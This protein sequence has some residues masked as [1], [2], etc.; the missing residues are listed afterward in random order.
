MIK[1]FLR[2]IENRLLNLPFMAWILLG[3][4]VTFFL[5]FIRPV[6]LDP[7]L[8][9]Q[10][11]PYI[12]AL[13]PI[14][15]DYRAI[16]S[17]SY[18]WFHSGIVPPTLYPPLTLI[19]F[20][21]FSFIS[22]ETGY[23]ILVGIIL[24]CYLFTTLILPRWLNPHKDTS[25]FA[26]LLFVSGLVSY[27]FQFELERGQWNLI[28]FAFSLA[29]IYIFHKQTKYRWLAYF[30]FSLSVQLKLFPA[31]FIFSLIDNFSD[32]KNSLK[33]IIGLGVIN[34]IAL[35]LFGINPVLDTIKSFNEFSYNRVFIFNL[36]LSSFTSF[37][38][39]KRI[40][41]QKRIVLWLIANKWLPELAL[42]TLFAL[43]FLIILVQ[44]YKKNT[45]GFNPY[46]FLACFIGACIIPS[47]SFD[48]KLSMLPASVAIAAPE[49]LLS[50]EDKKRPLI[51]GL[52]LVFSLAYSSMLYSYTNK[53]EI[54]QDNFPALL[55]ILI[56]CTIFSCMKSSKQA[57][58]SIV[59]S[60]T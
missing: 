52:T 7:S 43:C 6:F 23:Q 5:F 40:L 33:R 31:I 54:L 56:I 41:P 19:F 30:L 4:L 45:T 26:M 42:F 14:G 47:I 34:I 18:E 32:W 39:L 28:A 44:A 21:P 51:I 27:G 1:S 35:F 13:T 37:F 46:I 22:Y 15:N 24:I 49:I 53:P 25:A 17:Y 59:D 58:N 60:K 9:M 48:Y 57:R 20:A 2:Q 12:L 50:E 10:F 16:V 29:A 55:L 38:F 11:N 36:S 3:F 8:T